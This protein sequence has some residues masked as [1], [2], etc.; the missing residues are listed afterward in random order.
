MITADDQDGH[1]LSVHS[2]PDPEMQKF[3]KTC[4]IH[5]SLARDKHIFSLKVLRIWNHIVLRTME[6]VHCSLLSDSRTGETPQDA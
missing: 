3:K 4:K 1:D 6:T 2:V 5:G